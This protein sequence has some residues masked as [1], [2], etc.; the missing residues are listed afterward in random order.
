MRILSASIQRSPNFLVV[1]SVALFLS[2]KFCGAA[3]SL[4]A[5]DLEYHQFSNT[6]F[7]TGENEDQSA[8][9]LA[10]LNMWDWEWSLHNSYPIATHAKC[11]PVTPWTQ[12]SL[13][14]V[15]SDKK[16]DQAYGHELVTFPRKS[17][18]TLDLE[19]LLAK[20]RRSDD[21]VQS[22]LVLPPRPTDE[23]REKDL[24]TLT[25]HERADVK[26]DQYVVF[27]SDVTRLR[28]YWVR[29]PKYEPR[30]TRYNNP[31]A[32]SVAE[33]GATS[34]SVALKSANLSFVSNSNAM[35]G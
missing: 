11:L 34:T 30:I 6:L 4:Q 35:P 7:V 29:A 14:A 20:N 9:V 13:L 31:V 25:L 23:N 19:D 24:A 18:D 10:S 17:Y 1:T 32:S 26:D 16:E 3:V 15:S 2:T 33:N 28:N 12:D 5:V 27:D 22:L 21:Q 8:C